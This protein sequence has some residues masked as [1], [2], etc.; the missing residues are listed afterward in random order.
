[1]ILSVTVMVVFLN[2]LRSIRNAK[3]KEKSRGLCSGCAFAHIQYGANEKTATFCTYGGGV[4][5]V[6]IDVMYCTDYR[7]RNAAVR[8]VTIGFAYEEAEPMADIAA[9]EVPGH[10]L[11]FKNSLTGRC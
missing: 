5:P 9:G 7:D 1:M 10:G 11:A 3:R 4:R 6:T 8:V 2:I